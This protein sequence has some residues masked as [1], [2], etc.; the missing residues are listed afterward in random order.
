MRSTQLGEKYNVSFLFAA[1]CSGANA[2]REQIWDD[3]AHVLGLDP[4]DFYEHHSHTSSPRRRASPEHSLGR[5]TDRRFFPV[6]RRA[7]SPL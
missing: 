1:G 2:N 7:T 6:D 3:F 4:S 5:R